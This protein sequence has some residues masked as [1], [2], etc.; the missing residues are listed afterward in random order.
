M[1]NQDFEDIIIDLFIRRGIEAYVLEDNVDNE[2]VRDQLKARRILY[3]FLYDI[4]DS[5]N[6]LKQETSDE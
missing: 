2:T 4:I 1:H 5:A 3:R 6:I